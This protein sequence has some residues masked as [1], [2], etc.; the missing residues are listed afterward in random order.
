VQS[1]GHGPSG[2]ST[3]S[4]EPIPAE[5][6]SEEQAEVLDSRLPLG[7]MFF[8]DPENMAFSAPLAF[9]GMERP[10]PLLE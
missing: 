9:R 4:V 3:F 2:A 10:L 8:G 6:E 5:T 1:H 7:A